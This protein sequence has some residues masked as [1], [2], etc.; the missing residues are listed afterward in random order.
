MRTYTV[1]LCLVGALALAGTRAAAVFAAPPP[2]VLTLAQALA[3]GPTPSGLVLAVGAAGVSLPASAEPPPADASLDNIAAAFGEGTEVFGSVTVVAPATRVVL[4]ENPT[5]PNVAA[6]LSAFSAFKLLAAGLN[7]SQW[8]ALTSAGGLGLADLTEPGQAALFHA[9]YPH[10]HLW[11]SSEDPELRKLADSQRTDIQDVS[12]QIDGTRIRL[13]QIANFYL[14]DRAGKILYSSAERPDAAGRLHTWTPKQDP[15]SAL[16]AVTLR[17]VVP[18]TPKD[19]DLPFDTPAFQT[20]ISTKGL[21]TVEDVIARIS[22][23]TR[24]EIYA[25]PRYAKRKITL[26]G[27]AA[28]APAG[29][30]LRALALAVAG[31]YR[32]VGPAFVLTD[33]LSGV[34]ARRKRLM[35]WEEAAR[36]ASAQL[37]D[38][39]GQTMLARRAAE[40][41]RL[42]SFGDPLALTAQQIAAMKDDTSMP[43]VPQSFG[44]IVPFAALTPAQ[45]AW[46]K[47]TSEVFDEQRAGSTLPFYLDGEDLEEADLTGKVDLSLYLRMQLLVPGAPTPVD[48]DPRP[49]FLLFWPGMAAV[50]AHLAS[51]G[52]GAGQADLP[53]APPLASVLRSRPRRALLGHPRSRAEVD[54]LLAAMRKLGLNELWLDVFSAGV[55][56]VPGSRLS[57][58]TLPPGLDILAEALARTQGTGIT[59]YADL[60]LLSWGGD[61][62]DSALDLTIQGETNVQAAVRAHANAPDPDYDDH[63]KEI[64]FAP[65]PAAVSPASGRVRDDLTALVRS[66][67][68]RPGL[69]GFIWEDADSDPELGYTP[70]M[71]LAFLRDQHADPL[72]ITSENYLL[73]DASLPGFDDAKADEEL[74][75]RWKSARTQ[76]IAD[77]LGQM[78]RALPPSASALP[79]LM[80]QSAVRTDWLASWDDPNS[81]PP[82]LRTLFEQF[83]FPSRDRVFALARKQGRTTLLRERVG[84]A[85]DPDELARS[86]KHDLDEGRWPGFVLDFTDAGA[87]AG[88][89]PLA[90]LIHAAAPP[91]PPHQKQALPARG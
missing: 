17:A 41:R 76:S 91:P 52:K 87:T 65:P 43:G 80:E 24:R 70:D 42:P 83:P 13:G 25:D 75:V 39:A 47:H 77:M 20:Q 6:D 22:A 28:S 11:I 64:P 89:T 38:Q 81:L 9:L 1:F 69:A 85:D 16:H 49:E 55:A 7:D 29:D 8:Q 61:A 46:A 3:A 72:D 44:N 54:T 32:Q 14:H 78:R 74:L 35:E 84:D 82:P 62:P 31:T 45:Q 79:I 71:R 37:R 60:S 27:S 19:G 4:N 12:D 59:V 86:L 36:Q 68:A 63:N 51:V 56:H 18:N 66:L 33:D 26:L 34:G 30:L 50:E 5:A 53:P 10:G 23:Q 90:A 40:A 15:P 88:E 21:R 73:A 67:A 58:K 2:T 57:P 48:T